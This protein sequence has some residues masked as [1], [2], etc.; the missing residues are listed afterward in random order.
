MTLDHNVAYIL[1][2]RNGLIEAGFPTVIEGK[3]QHMLSKVI[4]A[5][6]ENGAALFAILCGL[7]LAGVQGWVLSGWLMACGVLALGLG[8]NYRIKR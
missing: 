1:I 3:F 5:L 2:R 7:L 4:V 6:D 8:L